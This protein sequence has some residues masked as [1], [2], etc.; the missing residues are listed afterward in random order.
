MAPSHYLNQCW[1]IVNWTL[2]TNFSEILIETVRFSF[3]KMRLKVSSA[4]WRRWCLGLNV[5]THTASIT[6]ALHYNSGMY[7]PTFW[8]R[9]EYCLT[10]I[11]WPCLTGCK[12]HTLIATFSTTTINLEKETKHNSNAKII[13][14]I[15]AISRLEIFFIIHSH[16]IICI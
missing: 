9:V 8:T 13:W 7:S 1:N 16:L 11:C 14:E 15:Q 6:P 10:F 12:R 3:E 2:R 4:K 5:L